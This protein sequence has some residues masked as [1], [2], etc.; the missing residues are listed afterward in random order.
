MFEEH[1][2]AGPG[3]VV[4]PAGQE[5]RPEVEPPR[6]DLLE[7]SRE[8]C[9]L[10]TAPA[11]RDVLGG[12]ARPGD[13]LHVV[14]ELVLQKADDVEERPR[15]RQ[16]DRDD[17]RGDDADGEYNRATFYALRCQEADR[18]Y[19]GGDRAGALEV[20]A[21]LER[22]GDLYLSADCLSWARDRTSELQFSLGAEGTVTPL[23]AVSDAF[24]INTGLAVG[25]VALDGGTGRAP[26]T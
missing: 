23:D 12:V 13:R 9:Q 19:A 6:D 24:G 5:D 10:A 22:E 4:A 17:R 21:S 15:D 8:L 25:A 11:V 20:Y 1:P 16:R 18:L 3:H 26:R 7:S 2:E 14:A